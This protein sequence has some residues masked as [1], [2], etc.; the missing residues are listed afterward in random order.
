VLKLSPNLRQIAREKRP[1]DEVSTSPKKPGGGLNIAKVRR[2][3]LAPGLPGA[4]LAWFR[5]RH[6][7][8]GVAV[9]AAHIPSR[10][11]V[12]ARSI[13]SPSAKARSSCRHRC[14][15]ILGLDKPAVAISSGVDGE[16]AAPELT[17]AQMEY[18]KMEAVLKDIEKRGTIRFD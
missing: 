7:L 4:A 16:A 12:L 15:Q 10:A 13:G 1:E 6:A 2:A 9:A 8:C 18:N 14:S 3:Y 17:Q 5:R 11:R